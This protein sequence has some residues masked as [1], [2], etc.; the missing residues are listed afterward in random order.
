MNYIEVS[1]TFD[2]CTSENREIIAAILGEIGFES[3]SDIPEG[4]NAYI[5]KNI[6]V[7]E[8][9][10]NAL[11]PIKPILENIS[12]SI[13]EIEQQN[14]NAEW[15]K[16]FTPITVGSKCRIR[17]PFHE[18]DSNFEY[19]LIIEPKMS[20]GTGHHATTTLMIEFM[21]DIDFENKTVLD[22]GCGTGVLAILAAKQNAKKVTGI[23]VDN[24][25]YVNSIENAQRNNITNFEVFEG[26][27]NLLSD[28][29]FDVIIA[30]I[31]RNI[32]LN[33][34][35]KYANSLK[36][37]GILL[38]SGFYSHDLPMLIEKAE[39][40]DFSFSKKIEKDNWTAAKF[41]KQA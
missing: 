11:D 31:N 12:V 19:D 13:T 37:N 18:A 23:D 10:E 32:L 8:D 21:L 33:D 3:F 2:N 25:A 29:S 36:P 41:Y 14:W 40:L 20:F 4:L 1:L 6:F 17:A 38:L 9:F 27:A 35:D 7:K 39:N 26:D 5:P 34:M 16:N 30:N 22:M 15:E 28:K 24:W